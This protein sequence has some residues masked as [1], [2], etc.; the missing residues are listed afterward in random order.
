MVSGIR[1]HGGWFATALAVV[2]A[3][4]W[5]LAPGQALPAQPAVSTQGGNRGDPLSALHP[6]E[7]QWIEGL[8]SVPGWAGLMRVVSD[9]GPGRYM[10]LVMAGLLFCA[11]P[12]L[13]F[14][15][16][17]LMFFTLWLREI[18]ALWLHSPRPYWFGPPITTWGKVAA[19][20]HTFGL[21]SGHAMVGSALWLFAA[22]EYGRR[23]A[24]GVA[25]ATSLAIAFSRLYL[26]VH[27][28][29][30]VILGLALGVGVAWAWRRWEPALERFWFVVVPTPGRALLGVAVGLGMAAVG[31]VSCHWLG[32]SPPPGGWET[33]V[34]S[35]L[36]PETT[37][38]QGGAVTGILVGVAMLG[39]WAKPTGPW[40]MRL[41]RLGVAGVA[42]RFGIEPA[43]DAILD[44]W[45]GTPSGVGRLS[46]VFA[47]AAVKAWSVWWFFPWLYLRMR[48]SVAMEWGVAATRGRVAIG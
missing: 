24:W 32:Q 18:L 45:P 17:L 7:L 26:G 3:F 29:S 33:Y 10:I 14:R 48:Q 44:G 12:R 11:N 22:A 15:M 1:F 21:P 46:V 36:N 6:A 39:C 40:W 25:V 16:T 41:V 42:L 9:L 47:V 19:T 28:V 30:D 31:S 34:R 38:A 43:G 27:F 35:A 13:A 4:S 5:T 8:Q 2:L 37:V 23:W 20:R